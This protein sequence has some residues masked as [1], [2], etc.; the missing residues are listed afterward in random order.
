MVRYVKR[1]IPKYRLP[2][3]CSLRQALA[4]GRSLNLVRPSIGGDDL[5][6]LQYTG[7]TTGVAKGAMLTHRNLLANVAQCLGVY[8]PVLKAGDRNNFV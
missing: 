7:G 8:G 2:G 4:A 6:L 3:A 5:A 1:L